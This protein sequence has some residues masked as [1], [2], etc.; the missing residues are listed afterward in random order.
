MVKQIIQLYLLKFRDP[1][2]ADV[3]NVIPQLSREGDNQK[4]T[5]SNS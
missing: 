4:F 3:R 2:D 5:S 1:H